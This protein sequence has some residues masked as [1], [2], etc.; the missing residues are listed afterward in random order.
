MNTA[1]WPG[2]VSERNRATLPLPFI[3]LQVAPSP[4]SSPSAAA[5]AHTR[6]SSRRVLV[7]SRCG[8]RAEAIGHKIITVPSLD[9]KVTPES[10]SNALANNAHYPHMAKPRLVYVSNATEM[11]TLYTKAELSAISDLCKQRGLLLY[12]DGARLGAALSAPKNDLTLPD[13]VQLTDIFWIGGTKVGML[14]GEAIIISNPLLA[15]DFSFHVKQRGGL[16]AKGRTLGVQFLEMF[17]T[18]LFFDLAQHTNEMAQLLSSRIQDAGYKLAAETET[19]QVFAILPNSLLST[20]QEQFQF[21]IWEKMDDEHT[22]VRLVLLKKD[23]S[24]PEPR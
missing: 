21:Y 9:G 12:L 14:L 18:N 15:E 2:T 11:G 10:I 24:K 17:S 13:L 6:P 7:T 20:L 23:I 5:C 1:T 19:N 4:T 3:S 22:M 8:R 16:L